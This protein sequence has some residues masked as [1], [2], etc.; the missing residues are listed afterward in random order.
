M[1]ESKLYLN[2]LSMLELLLTTKLLIP[3][4]FKIDLKKLDLKK[5][6]FISRKEFA[7]V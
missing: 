3:D 5:L 7:Y 1:K 4:Y 6:Q 2:C